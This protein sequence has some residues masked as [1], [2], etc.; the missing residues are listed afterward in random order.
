MSFRFWK[1]QNDN[2]W[3][4]TDQRE[5]RTIIFIAVLLITAVIGGIWTLI[6]ALT[7]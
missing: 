2:K 7:R 1:K 4:E 3:V 6:Y 5:R